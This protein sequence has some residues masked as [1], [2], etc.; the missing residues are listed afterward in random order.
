LAST[1]HP[2]HFEV[3]FEPFGR[4]ESY[5]THQHEGAGLGLSITKQLV[6]LHGGLID[7][8][9]KVGEGTSFRVFIPTTSPDLPEETDGGVDDLVSQT[10]QTQNPTT[11]ITITDPGLIPE[12]SKG[13]QEDGIV[14][15][16]VT[17]V[18]PSIE[19]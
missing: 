9:S 7:L 11:T 12:D 16:T 1:Q 17:G 8:L 15:D 14:S 19:M 10:S 6:M 13:R 5:I 3:V 4:V 2:A 18:L